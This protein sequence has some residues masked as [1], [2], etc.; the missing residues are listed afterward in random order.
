MKLK[1]TKQL[2]SKKNILIYSGFLFIPVK[3]P[4]LWGYSFSGGFLSFEFL[5]TVILVAFGFVFALVSQKRGEKRRVSKDMAKLKNSDPNFS[6]S[7]FLDFVA[8]IYTKYYSNYEFKNLATF[9]SETE[10]RT[11]KKNIGKNIYDVIIKR[12]RISR[13]EQQNLENI[14]VIIYAKYSDNQKRYKVKERW[15]FYR[16]RGILSQEA[17]KMRELSCPNCG[18]GSFFS[19]KG[20]CESCGTLIESGKMQ[21]GVS[22]HLIMKKII[23]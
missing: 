21:W 1:S 17:K 11:A 12:I 20:I 10:I 8:A 18:D 7:L 19:E 13:I 4:L 6:K 14:I 9:L 3:I 23:I 5:V 22:H 16:N 2:Q 15:V